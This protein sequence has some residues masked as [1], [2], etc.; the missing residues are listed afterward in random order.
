M[1]YEA[2]LCNEILLLNL[3]KAIVLA[4]K[5]FEAIVLY[6]DNDLSKIKSKLY[7]NSVLI[8]RHIKINTINSIDIST[9]ND[10]ERVAT[11][12]QVY[13]VKKWFLGF[14]EKVI[15]EI[16]TST[17]KRG[18]AVVEEV[19]EYIK[20][21]YRDEISLEQIAVKVCV[22]AYYLSRLFK[23]ETGTNFNIYLTEY[24]LNAA[25]RLIRNTK[26]T[27]KEIAYE[28]GFNSQ[29]YFCRVFK[30]YF[31]ITPSEYIKNISKS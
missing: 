19:K 29:A 9:K 10:I 20:S 4:E 26:M 12:T 7:E 13:A 18:S 16:E 2:I 22:T 21:N 28:T 15:K 5:I 31:D 27:I 14:V 6:E 17:V 23:K 30:K 8:K 25:K 11:F 3:E 24:R 1:D